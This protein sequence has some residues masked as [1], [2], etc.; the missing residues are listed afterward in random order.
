ML[1]AAGAVPAAGVVTG[2]APHALRGSWRPYVALSSHL[3]AATAL[4]PGTPWAHVGPASLGAQLSLCRV[5]I[6]WRGEMEEQ[7]GPRGSTRVSPLTA[8]LPPAAAHSAQAVPGR[9]LV[10][11][12]YYTGRIK[13]GTARWVC[14]NRAGQKRW[15]GAV[16]SHQ[17]T[18]AEGAVVNWHP[19]SGCSSAALVEEGEQ[20]PAPG[21]NA[22][23][24]VNPGKE[25]RQDVP[26]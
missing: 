6:Y 7:E 25:G 16:D 14:S 20:P 2:R 22:G 17:C 26:A 1:P 12:R 18:P 10:K 9:S 21:D 23:G 3:G 4:E 19:D 11:L 8:V 15:L 24:L 5:S 13:E